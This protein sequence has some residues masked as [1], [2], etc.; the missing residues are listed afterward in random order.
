MGEL[1]KEKVSESHDHKMNFKS[2][3][4]A[5]VLLVLGFIAPALISIYDSEWISQ[6]I[7]QGALW[8]YSINSYGS[9]FSPLTY[10]FTII[11]LWILRAIPAYQVYRYYDGKTTKK[12]AYIASLVGDG[13]FIFPA[14]LMMLMSLGFP[15]FFTAPL[16]FQF[17]IG[18]LIL[19]KIPGPE[20]TTPWKAP[21]ESKSWWEKTSDSPPKKKPTDDDEDRKS[22]V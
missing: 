1:V 17:V 2:Y 5:V 9:G 10:D 14:V 15:S 13:L 19:W 11:L 12:R 22:V 4:I 18:V 16:P 7:I 3:L 20:P 6:T 8:M 21:T